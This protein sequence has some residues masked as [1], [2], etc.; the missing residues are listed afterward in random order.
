MAKAK[1][2]KERPS[3]YFVRKILYCVSVDY[4]TLKTSFLKRQRRR[5]GLKKLFVCRHPTLDL[6]VRS[7]NQDFFILVRV[8]LIPR[9]L[10]FL[11]KA[12]LRKKE[13]NFFRDYRYKR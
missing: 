11:I 7:V 4:N 12:W 9:A 13:P 2:I 10:P 5:A 3:F 8:S 1:L 6:R